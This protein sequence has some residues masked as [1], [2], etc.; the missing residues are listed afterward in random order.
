MRQRSMTHPIVQSLRPKQ[1]IKNL[2]LFA[3]IVF[4]KNLFDPV[5][6]FRV[7]QGFVIFCL[8]SSGVYLLND[9][10][11]L[12][13]DKKH[14]EKSKRPLASGAVTVRSVLSI[15][16]LLFIGS[17]GASF[18]Y[19]PGFAAA[20]VTYAVLMIAYTFILKHVVILDV[21]T[22]AIGFVIRALAGALLIQVPISSWFLVCTI[23]LALFVGLVKRRHEL[24]LLGGQAKDHRK[25]LDVYSPALLDQMITISTASSVISYT[26]YTTSANAVEKFGTGNLVFTV[27]FI[28]YGIFRYLYLIYQKGLGG[29]PEQIFLSDRPTL[30]NC[31][32]YLLVVVF[33]LYVS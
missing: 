15:S 3:G 24:I 1:W 18:F 7:V 26:L 4:S 19:N 27:P 20:V 31:L 10:V 22:I 21:L 33:I 6:F 32:L 25:I 2:L 14:P 13:Q 16:L 17:I 5:L 11:D 23:F 28:L 8:I 30:I 12:E 9:V 29:S